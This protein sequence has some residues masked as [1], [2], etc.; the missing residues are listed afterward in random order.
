MANF[1]IYR[2]RFFDLRQSAIQE[3]GLFDI[4]MPQFVP[5]GWEKRVEILTQIFT[6]LKENLKFQEDDTVYPHRLVDCPQ[7]QNVVIMRI[8]NVKEIDIEKD[9]KRE[10]TKHNPSCWVY[11]DNRKGV[12][13]IAVQ[14]SRDS[15]YSTDMVARIL[16]KSINKLL[17]PW[18]ISIEI[19]AQRYPKE[20]WKAY[21]LN[22]HRV[23]GATFM[24]NEDS[25]QRLNTVA[26]REDDIKDAPESTTDFLL[27]LEEF[28]RETGGEPSIEITAK[29]G[30]ILHLREDSPR[31]K[32]Y[33]QACAD[34]GLPVKF[35][36]IDGLEFTCYAE[37][38]MEEE[39]KIMMQEFDDRYLPE[40][41]T[42]DLFNTPTQYVIEF[43][44]AIKIIRKDKEDP[45]DEKIA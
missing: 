29:K 5:D 7:N 9:F 3:P 1:S 25:F 24:L 18:G 31:V 23:N 45:D 30:C 12:R 11:I 19:R 16:E 21:R 38:G 28:Y 36:T 43:L 2:F 14:R 40:L 15:F 44:N 33:I 22:E 26:P 35:R 27:E 39:D 4:Q 13:H 17:L 42:D 37:K 8:A 10:K 32:R 34:A 41:G 20:F 6:D